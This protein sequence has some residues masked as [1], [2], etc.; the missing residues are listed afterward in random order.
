MPS[1]SVIPSQSSSAPLQGSLT[2]GWIIGLPSLQS[3][4][5][6]PSDVGEA[7]SPSPSIGGF[8]QP[9][10]RSQELGVQALASS[11]SSGVP[12]TQTCIVVLQVS[13][14]VQMSASSQS[15]IVVQLK[16]QSLSQPSPSS[17]L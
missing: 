16:V 8:A 3:V 4:P 17:G 13:R 15:A 5:Q 10:A 9:V 12:A 14:P 2:P 1:S 7:P 11:Q 6:A